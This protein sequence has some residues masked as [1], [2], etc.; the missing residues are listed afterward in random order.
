MTTNP[1]PTAEQIIGQRDSDRA[2]ETTVL[3]RLMMR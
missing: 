2:Q 1:A 3:L